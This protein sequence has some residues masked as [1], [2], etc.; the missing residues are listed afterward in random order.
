M[1]Q[2]TT[3]TVTRPAERS[4]IMDALLADLR[5]LDERLTSAIDRLRM[6]QAPDTDP[7]QRGLLIEES[8]VDSWLAGLG[9]AKT[10]K[11]YVEV[12]AGLTAHQESRLSTLGK[13]FGLSRLEQA[14]I[15]TALAPELDLAYGNLYSY[16]QDDVTKKYCTLDLV[17]ALW[18]P[19]L[20]DKLA[21][22]L[23]L[24]PEAS[25]RS[26]LLVNLDES[27]HSHAPLLARPFSLDPRIAS[28][29]LGQDDPDPGLRGALTVARAVHRTG[30]WAVGWPQMASLQRMAR[31]A[32]A[33]SRHETRA[34]EGE[35]GK[36]PASGLALWMR[37]PERQAKSEVAHQLAASL[38]VPLL[39]VDTPMLM[40]AVSDTRQAL[41]RALRE[42]RLQG[43]ILLWQDADAMLARHDDGA[44]D[45]SAETGRLLAQWR[46]C[47]LFDLRASAPIYVNGG[48][49][50]VELDFPAPTNE[51][52]R[53]LWEDA[54]GGAGNLAA[55][56][57]LPLLSGAFRL[58]GEQIEAAAGSA[59]HSATWR[60]A[61]S[62][63]DEQITMR[64]LLSACRAHS[65]QG[66]GALSRKVTPRYTWAD[67]VLPADRLAQLKEMCH[68][69]RYG[70]MV[71]EQWGFDRKL[72]GGKG[73]NVLFAGHPGTG[74]TMAA[75]VVATDLGLEIY[76]VDLAGVV[77][78]Y[79][80]ETEKNLEKIFREGQTSNAILF[81]DEADSLFGKRSAVKD[82]HDRYANIETSYL[83]QRME[84]YD[85]IVILATNLR[86]NM[87]DAFVRRLHGAIEFPMP[88]EPDRIE[89]WQRTFPVE[90]PLSPDADL[91]FLARQFKL[92]GGNI[93]NIILEA[94]FFAAE[95]GTSIN[96]AH[97]V[98]ATRRE[99]QK[100]GKL[101]A[102]SDFGPYAHLS[103][104]SESAQAPS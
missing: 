63:S 73:L 62:G 80:G 37:G 92:S 88:E 104:S 17:V 26:N 42:A 67:L 16:V 49:L 72:A 29:L 30:D 12:A 84:E 83:L 39:T 78:K 23:L 14:I 59:R 77:S 95:A 4:S 33:G 28:Y 81:F 32:L 96:M 47:V 94:A 24:S 101:I 66:L 55:D 89:I 76:K 19:G 100:I 27:A 18:C 52:R 69:V 15:L 8:D 40:A 102:D 86:K 54:L 93:K 65:N 6:S 21:A 7:T 50:T 70:P 53:A 103:R 75:E 74:K 2:R 3:T 41:H 57:D 9:P 25:L 64:D 91:A 56:V 99:H 90:A 68:H 43:G 45:P 85:G 13:V 71:F 10:D 58:T 22:R 34:S 79:I 1:Q 61:L 98:R 36:N 87:D 20:P 38:D 35:S 5:L 48:P 11:S 82:S 44:P 60:G 51:Q 46:G 31:S 97:L